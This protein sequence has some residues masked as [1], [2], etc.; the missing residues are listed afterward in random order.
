MLLVFFKAF[1][2]LFNSNAQ[3]TIIPGI[4]IILNPTVDSCVP[5]GSIIFIPFLIKKKEKITPPHKY[6]VTMM[7][8]IFTI[9]SVMMIGFLY[10]KYY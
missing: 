3:K 6:T 7:S 2:H 4:I 1:I 5:S 10:V 8:A 9:I